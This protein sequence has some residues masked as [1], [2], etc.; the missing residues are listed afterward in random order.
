MRQEEDDSLN[1]SSDVGW[2]RNC[3]QRRPLCQ[4]HQCV[5]CHDGE[6]RCPL[7]SRQPGELCCG[8]WATGPLLEPWQCPTCLRVVPYRP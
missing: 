1:I 5:Q 2:C 7:P 8:W 3:H 4:F 6:T